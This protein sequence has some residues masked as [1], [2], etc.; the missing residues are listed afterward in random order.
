LQK[1]T[2]M[3]QIARNTTWLLLAVFGL[4]ITP[5]ELVHECYGHEDTRCNAGERASFEPLHHHCEI[6]QLACPHYTRPEKQALAAVTSV[7][8]VF[9]DEVISS[10]AVPARFWFNLRAPP[11]S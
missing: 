7:P 2:E 1:I 9:A 11:L 3:K 5:K 8:A 10:P 4:I 6:L